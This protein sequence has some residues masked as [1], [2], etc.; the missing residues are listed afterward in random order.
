VFVLTV[1]LMAKDAPG[2]DKPVT[3]K[4]R[5][6]TNMKGSLL[7]LILL[8]SV[9]VDSFGVSTLPQRKCRYPQ[10][11]LVSSA[12]EAEAEGSSESFAETM[13]PI[14]ELIDIEPSPFERNQKW[15]EEATAKLRDLK[16]FP[17]GT[18]TPDDVESMVGLMAAWVRRRSVDA[19]LT[20]EELLKRIVDDLRAGNDSIQVTTRMYTIAM[21]AWA[22]SGVKGS[23]QRAQHIH[24]VMVQM[25]KETGDPDIAPT[26]ISYNTLLNAWGKT[27]D[28]NGTEMA[29]LVLKEMI[30]AWQAGND[31]LKPDTITFT[32]LMDA[33]S[34]NC[35]PDGTQRA[36]ELFHMMDEFGITKNV[37]TFSAMQNVYARS[38]RP[39][40]PQL[41]EAVLQQ[42]MDSYREGDISARPNVVNFNAIL[43]ALA[44]T[45]SRDSTERANELLRLMETPVEEGGYGVAPDRLCFAL[46]ILACARCPD[47]QY[48]A[49]TAEANLVKMES[50]AKREEERR[51]EVSSAAPPTV[52]I[53]VECFNVV[54]QAFARSG[55]KDAVER[56]LS[57]IKRMEDY[58]DQG[59]EKVQPNIRSW[60]ALL[61]AYARSNNRDAAKKAE[62]V[63][64]RLYDKYQSGEGTVKPDAFSWA[65]VLSAYQKSSDPRS[66]ERADGIVRKMEELYE[67]KKIDCPPDVYHYT[68]ACAAWAR[69]RQEG[70]PARCTQILSHMFERHKAGYPGV[71]PNIRTYNSVLDCLSRGGYEDR[72]EKL[73]YHMLRRYREGDADAAPDAFSFNSVINAFTRSKRK[74]SGRR[75]EAILD[76][77]L[78]YYNEENPKVRLDIRCFTHITGYYAKSKEPDAPYRAEYILNRLLSLYEAGVKDLAPT[79]FAFTSVMDA[80][81]QSKHP[82]AGVTAERLLKRMREMKKKYNLPDFEINGMV[83]YRVMNAWSACGDEDAGLRAEVILANLERGYA[84][85][86]KEMRP[87]SRIYGLALS[88]WSRS[89]TYGK[90]GRALDILRRMQK[91]HQEG[92]DWVVPSGHAFSLVIN[93]CAFASGLDDEQK[94]AFNIA[95]TV[96]DEVLESDDI[97]PSSLTFGWYIQACARLQKADPVLR[98]ERLVKAFQQCCEHGLVNDFVLARFRD[99]ATE[100]MF[101]KAMSQASLPESKDGVSSRVTVSQLPAEWTKKRIDKRTFTDTRS[102]WV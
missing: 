23:A 51:L 49:D 89:S 100:E 97:E 42:M 64:N 31:E 75:A 53:D 60:N 88:A 62:D 19:A 41:A 68:I 36:E 78:E 56:S 99:A 21:D 8:G 69:S 25:Y 55:R 26:N 10:C 59:N 66:A 17:M 96:F 40:A 98:Q 29:E 1:K 50:R 72:A 14:D 86:N 47:T 91:Q 95:T 43:N 84:S 94:E 20:V 52:S 9:R 24:D 65:A 15:L 22:K 7:A 35:G 92:N 101:R 76:V 71:K 33:Y 30:E 11:L 77:M 37:Y 61:N 87:D 67:A 13:L 58:V 83:M 32:T 102:H 74:G 63:L 44:R 80:Y 27:V 5:V 34:R 45:P 82:D 4:R 18:L 70:A 81:S 12:I 90:A 46:T 57:I 48:G 39:N 2:R 85:G 16:T 54:L 28:G 79:V 6:Q 93:S 3:Y 38:Q 73:L